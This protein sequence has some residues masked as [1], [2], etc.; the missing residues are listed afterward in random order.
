MTREVKQ[1][2]GSGV[3]D[4]DLA[5]TRFKSGETKCLLWRKEKKKS[6]S[7]D[8]KKKRGRSSRDE[9]VKKY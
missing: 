9:G 5:E 4:I 8:K 6:I 1:G 3:R 7:N 2:F